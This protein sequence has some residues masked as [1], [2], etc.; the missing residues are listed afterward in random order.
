MSLA[1]PNWGSNEIDLSKGL[2][3]F[4]LKVSSIGRETNRAFWADLDTHNDWTEYDRKLREDAEKLYSDID[5]VASELNIDCNFFGS[6][7]RDACVMVREA[8]NLSIK[9]RGDDLSDFER[10]QITTRINALRNSSDSL[11]EEA[12]GGL[13]PV[14]LKLVEMGYDPEYL[15]I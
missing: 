11:R 1:L 9:L 3:N 14:F 13:M 7:M 8:V 2:N 15:K 4:H 10:S 6:M 12:E 5:S